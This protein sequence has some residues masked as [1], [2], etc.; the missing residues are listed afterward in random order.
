[1]QLIGVFTLRR[2]CDPEQSPFNES[3]NF[4][5]HDKFGIELNDQ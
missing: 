4:A 3:Q 5:S 1:M 2:S